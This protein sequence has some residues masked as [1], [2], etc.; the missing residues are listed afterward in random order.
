MVDGFGIEE[1]DVDVT[2]PEPGMLELEPVDNVVPVDADE[3]RCPE[4]APMLWGT[5]DET[6]EDARME[7]EMELECALEAGEDTGDEGLAGEEE[8]VW[9]EMAE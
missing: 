4:D 2:V 6:A 9:T 1:A 5:E 8:L 7:P 3:G